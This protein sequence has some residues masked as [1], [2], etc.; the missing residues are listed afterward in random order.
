MIKKI[1]DFF[2][3]IGV[4]Y[5]FL[6]II[7]INYL[8]SFLNFKIDLS[9]NKA[10][11]LSQ[12]SK[13][14]LK[15]IDKDVEIKFFVSSDLPTKLIPF[16]NEVKDF[17]KEYE[18]YSKKIK[19]K[20]LDPKNDNKAY[21]EAQNL[22][23]PELQYSQL[24]TDS[25]QIKK[26]YF[27]IAIKYQDKKEIIPQINDL[28][29]LE[30]NIT[31]LIYKMTKKTEEK[32]AIIGKKEVFD[33]TGNQED[34]LSSL[35]KT[36]R[37]QY[38]LNF[39]DISDDSSVK[40]INKDH[41]LILVFDDNQK[42]YT[43]KE[44]EKIDNYLKQGGK[45]IF[46]VDGI[47]INDQGLFGQKAENGL[48]DYLKKCGVKINE[49]LVLSMA[50]ELV[51]FGSTNYQ[52][53]TNYP[54][55]IKTNNFNK[56]YNLFSNINVLTF[57][58]VSSVDLIDKNNDIIVSSISQSW[59][60]KYSTDSAFLV[61]PN[62]I[63]SPKKDD[64]KKQNLIAVKKDKND[65]KIVVVPSSRFV[66]ERFLSQNDNLDFV[67][68]LINEMASNGIL[69]GIRQ[70]TV[71]FYQL[72]VIQDSNLKN[73]TKYT[74][75]LLLPVIFAFYGLIRILKRSKKQF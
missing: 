39:L 60:K 8:L 21:E 69:S 24:E 65:L 1:F 75:I 30:Y 6:I 25:Y 5:L 32:I 41:R 57:P 71:S 20:I 58:W 31:S 56:K 15:K 18:N 34:D 53:I 50:S 7:G 59:I 73:I 36:I 13:N 3:K 64:F 35:K 14:I 26:V 61:D 52:F 37:D 23:I 49:N 47:W 70:R 12:S 62:S 16:K 38:S 66:Y 55:W 68:N 22:G 63:V 27:G 19:L 17:L 48:N 74:L 46:F 29:N 72:P 54:Y 2:K 42:K 11:S 40:E 10:Y 51:N 44:I 45:A 67:F 4:I 43:E 28:S 33:L 9:T